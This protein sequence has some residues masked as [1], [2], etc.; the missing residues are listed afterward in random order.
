MSRLTSKDKALIM[1]AIR[2]VFSRSELRR[3]IVTAAIVYHSDRSR[4]R[5]KNWVKCAIC[6]KPEAISSIQVDHIIPVTPLNKSLTDLSIHDMVIRTWCDPSNLQVLCKP[7]HQ[8]KSNAENA[9]RRKNKW[10]KK[11]SNQK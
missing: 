1:S 9:E 6:G 4:P 3:S 10:K 2:R 8:V 11:V 5:V 7:C